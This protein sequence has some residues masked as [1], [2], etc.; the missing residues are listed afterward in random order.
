[1]KAD[2]RLGLPVA[3]RIPAT[4]PGWLSGRR[5]LR[6]LSGARTPDHQLPGPLTR[7][8]VTVWILALLSVITAVTPSHPMGGTFA[9]MGLAVLAW[10]VW[11]GLRLISAS[12]RPRGC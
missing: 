9:M 4:V 2:G 5:V 12:R 8:L 3:R 6:R 11:L 7:A 1:M 10:I